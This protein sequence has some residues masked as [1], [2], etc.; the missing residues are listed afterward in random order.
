M[1]HDR[2][3]IPKGIFVYGKWKVQRQEC[4][5]VRE[6]EC[7]MDYLWLLKLNTTIKINPR[8]VD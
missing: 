6:E 8:I 2:E 5:N 3:K 7:H 4:Y 1:K